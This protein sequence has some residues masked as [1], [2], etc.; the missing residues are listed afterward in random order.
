MKKHIYQF[1][2]YLAAS[3]FIGLSVYG[4]II[5]MGG[6]VHT[7]LPFWTSMLLGLGAIVCIAVVV[8]MGGILDRIMAQGK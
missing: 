8:V 7:K 2:Q 5:F 1:I 4:V 6:E 3:V